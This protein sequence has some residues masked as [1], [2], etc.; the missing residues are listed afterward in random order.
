MDRTLHRGGRTLDPMKPYEQFCPV[1]QALEVVGDRWTLLVVRELLSGSHRFVEILNGVPKMPRSM[2]SRRL[3][4]LEAARLVR[5]TQT[6]QGAGYELTDAGRA[7]ET[8][9]M[10]L[11]LW[12]RRWAH[13]D[14][15]DYDLDPQLLLWDMRRRID[16][17]AIPEGTTLIRFE[18]SGGK[19]GHERL[20][21]KIERGEGDVCLTHP[22]FDETLVVFASTR[23][24]VEVWMGERDFEQ[25]IRSKV[26]TV[27]GPP[28]LARQLPRWFRLNVFVELERRAARA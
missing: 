19:R 21:L 1:A 26:I 20:W 9:V 22:G 10:H 4:D 7:L 28:K 17:R 18:L 24:L 25:A 8:I 14:L 3:Q 15:E 5:R 6:Q 23:T 11:G 16:P 27:E 13:R 12:S 2:L